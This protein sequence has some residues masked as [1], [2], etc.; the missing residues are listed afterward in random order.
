MEAVPLFPPLV[1]VMVAEPAA[2][3]ATRPAEVTVAIRLLELDQVI[4]R[5]LNVF[6]ALS[7]AT[8]ASCWVPPIGTLADAGLTVTDATGTTITV[9]ADVPLCPSDVAVT[10]AEPAVLAVTRPVVLTVATAALP[11]DHVMTR[12]DKGLPPASFGV[13]VSRTVWPTPRV[14]D[15]GLTVTEATG[16]L[17]TVTLAVPLC[18]SLVAVIVAEP[19]PAAVTRPAPLTVATAALLLAHVT[20]RPVSTL[21]A[22]SSVVA[23]NCVVP[24]T[25]TVA[26]AGATATVATGAGVTVTVAVSDRPLESF[27]ATTLTWPGLDPAL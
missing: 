10:V 19:A 11:L 27:L 25:M 6:P 5:P 1:V 20:V 7:L 17:E 14:A 12:P 26:V 13:A 4:V 8:A 2:T 15:A 22:E 16:T 23:C 9:I 18:P 3:P 24:P 21:L